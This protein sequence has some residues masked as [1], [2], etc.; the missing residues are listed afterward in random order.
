MATSGTVSTTVFNT[1]KVIDHAMRR[2]GVPAQTIASEHIVIA[3]DLLWLQLSALLNDTLPLWTITKLLLPLYERTPT[4]QTPVGTVELLDVN[5]RTSARLTGTASSS[6]GTADNAFDGDLDTACTQVTQAGHI[7]TQLASAAT[8]P[9]FG[10]LPNATGTW[11]V[12]MQYS[13]DGVSWTTLW[14][15]SAL[16]VTDGEWYWRD[17]E[18]VPEAAYWRLQANGTTILDVTE[19]VLQNTSQD[20]VMAQLNRNDYN[21]LPN[22]TR[23]GRPTQFWF[24][25]T[26]TRPEIVV[27]P[28]P[29]SVYTFA[30]VT[31]Y[32]KRHIQDVGTLQ[33]EL[34]VPQ[35]W[36]MAVVLQLAKE[37]C[38]EIKEADP[39]RIPQLDS[40]A[41]LA[42]RAAHTGESDGSDSY[43]RVNIGPYTR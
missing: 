40:D 20:I 5:L 15:E 6:E 28:A 25:R 9:T 35:R 41:A 43:F 34:E 21:N 23:T 11:D 7:Q 32:V 19:L 14:T 42:L 33:Q 37:L 38:R 39:S 24:N 36:Y 27:W 2:A 31:G 13:D 1:R 30:Q 3:Q 29:S 10:I 4:I 16:S 8:V 18:G 17:V 26:R 12:S 22:K